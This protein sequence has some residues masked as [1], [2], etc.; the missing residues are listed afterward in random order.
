MSEFEYLPIKD[1][2]GNPLPHKFYT[3]GAASR[4]LMVTF[5]GDHY[6]IDGPA[7]YYPN[8]FLDQAGWDT[9]LLTYGYQS[10]NENFSLEKIPEIMQESAQAVG[11][12]LDDHSY[13]HI[14]LLGKSL[15]CG[16]VAFLCQSEP[17]LTNA[18]AI[19]LTP[20]LGTVGFDPLFG[21]T[22]QP[23]FVIIGSEDRFYEQ[24]AEEKL[25]QVRDFEWLLVEGLTHSLDKPGDLSA[26]LRAV[27]TI[28]ERI[29]EFIMN[30]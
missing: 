9:L 15:G 25:R 2:M 8:E 22:T 3:H 20:P 16:V 5:P 24:G 10:R 26:S 28:T 30:G 29:I 6:G 19:Y 18:C 14:A 13:N 1:A 7:L 4:G 21:E 27:E 23:A 11:A 17:R 12:L